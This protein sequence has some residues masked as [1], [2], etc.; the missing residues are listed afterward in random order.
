MGREIMKSI[1]AVV[2]IITLGVLLY[3][4]SGREEAIAN[5]PAEYYTKKEMDDFASKLMNV[6]IDLLKR[7]EVLEK[8]NKVTPPKGSMKI[9]KK[10]EKAN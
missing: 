6:N 10:D 8:K 2:F 7:V 4:L 9:V 5:A 1:P 3:A